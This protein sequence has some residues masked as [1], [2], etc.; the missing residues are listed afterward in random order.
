MVV[1]VEKQSHEGEHGSDKKG[2]CPFRRWILESR[3]RKPRPI[4]TSL[5][6]HTEGLKESLNSRKFN[7]ILRQ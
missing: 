1:D 7:F 6:M 2:V 5:I 4:E 3:K